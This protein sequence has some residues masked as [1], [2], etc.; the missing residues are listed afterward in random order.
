MQGAR[1]K[2]VIRRDRGL[3]GR[4][5]ILPNAGHSSGETFEMN[6]SHFQIL[7]SIQR[8]RDQFVWLIIASEQFPRTS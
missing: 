1:D 2:V 8:I 7:P 5:Q 6:I 4:V 3:G